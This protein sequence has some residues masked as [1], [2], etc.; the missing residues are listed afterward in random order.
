ML[1]FYCNKLTKCLI[2]QYFIDFLKKQTIFLEEKCAQTTYFVKKKQSLYRI[3]LYIY[4]V[5]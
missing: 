5:N 3:Y 1:N 2:D 4:I